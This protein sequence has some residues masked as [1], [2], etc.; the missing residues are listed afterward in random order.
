MRSEVMSPEHG[1]GPAVRCGAVKCTVSNISVASPG[2]AGA[3]SPGGG[4]GGDHAQTRR[5]PISVLS[6]GS[7]RRAL[8]SAGEL[9]ARRGLWTP[10][11][12]FKQA[13]RWR[14][15]ERKE[16]DQPAASTA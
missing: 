2:P 12:E 5:P 16:A 6:M 7:A 4:Q 13:M 15:D 3:C 1:V 9:S 11:A 14:R 10:R 8:L